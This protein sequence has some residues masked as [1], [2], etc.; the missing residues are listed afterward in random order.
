MMGN[1][2]S[3]LNVPIRG[4]V[5][6]GGSTFA[7]KRETTNPPLYCYL[8]PDGG[9]YL[10]PDGGYYLTGESNIDDYELWAEKGA[11]GKDG[12]D[13]AQGEKGEQGIQGEKGDKGDKGDKGAI[14]YSGCVT[15]TWDAYIPTQIYRNDSEAAT[16]AL[17]PTGIRYLDVLLVSN[18]NNASGYEAYECVK[19]CVGSNPVGQSYNELGISADG[20]WRTASNL[21]S[22]FIAK[23]I[24]L[25]ANI[26]FNAN[27]QLVILDDSNKVVAGMTGSRKDGNNVR[28]WAGAETPEDAPFKV[29]EDGSSYQKNA[30]VNGNIRIPWVTLTYGVIYRSEYVDVLGFNGSGVTDDK[31]ILQGMTGAELLIAWGDDANGRE[32]T[33]YNTVGMRGAD[34]TILIPSGYA[35]KSGSDT[36]TTE[37]RIKAGYMYKMV[38]MESMWVVMEEINV[39]KYY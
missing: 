33:I 13:G 5:M 36:Y 4:I 6:M 32:M 22:A 20:C 29:Y 26:K 27:G 2:H 18:D 12:K 19:T 38:G 24:A 14:G 10:T 3:G 7:A 30:Q 34:V 11:D 9:Y 8:T 16:D 31:L 28:I 39:D 23:F 1:W 15:R 35:I 21:V 37:F 25:D 17:E